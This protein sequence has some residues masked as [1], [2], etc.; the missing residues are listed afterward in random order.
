MKTAEEWIKEPAFQRQYVDKA[1]IRDIQ[2]DAY[3][4]G[5]QDAL[6][7]FDKTLATMDLEINK[8][9]FKPDCLK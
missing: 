6:T 5:I 2:L 4:Q 7:S 8:K 1:D 3:K 9:D